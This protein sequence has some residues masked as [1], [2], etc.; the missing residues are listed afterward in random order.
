MHNKGNHQQD[1]KTSYR[2]GE[3]ICERDQQRLTSKI[4]H[5]LV[6]LNIKNKQSKNAEDLNRH[7]FKED[8]QMVNGHMRRCSISLIIREM[9][10][11]TTMRYHH[12][13]VRTPIIGKPTWECK[14][15]YHCGDS[16]VKVNTVL[17]SGHISRENIIRK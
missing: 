9:Q 1:E 7:F 2:I 3:N 10:I 8:M 14:V 15:V 6:K 13:P 11:K 16:S 12:I 5:Q 4:Y 17:P